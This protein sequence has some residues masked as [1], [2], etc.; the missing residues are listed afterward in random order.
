MNHGPKYALAE[1][2]VEEQKTYWELK[3]MQKDAQVP[4]TQIK[5]FEEDEI[6]QLLLSSGFRDEDASEHPQTRE[7]FLVSLDLLVVCVGV[8]TVAG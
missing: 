4:E 7:D 6:I 8:G 1:L 3:D 5:D 2:S